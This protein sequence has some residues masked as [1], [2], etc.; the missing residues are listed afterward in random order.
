MKKVYF[1]LIFIMI[2][3][4]GCKKDEQHK[5]DNSIFEEIAVVEEIVVTKYLTDINDY[6]CKYVLQGE[7]AKSL[8]NVLSDLQGKKTVSGI[9]QEKFKYSFKIGDLNICVAN[10][11]CIVDNKNY[12]TEYNF[13]EFF[14]NFTE[15]IDDAKILF[16][17]IVNLDEIKK[18]DVTRVLSN[19]KIKLFLRNESKVKKFIEK[20]QLTRWKEVENINADLIYELKLESLELNIYKDANNVYYMNVNEKN[21]Q[22]NG[23]LEF[24]DGYTTEN[25]D[26]NSSGW[27]PW[28]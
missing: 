15:I 19:T 21:Y 22:T 17:E 9:E 5:V 18:I 26:S 1:L 20:I 14:G 7:D 4:A 27:L 6:E 13:D 11:F 8:I 25:T 12:R 2:F 28:V 10:D 16:T 23:T 24:L 3:I